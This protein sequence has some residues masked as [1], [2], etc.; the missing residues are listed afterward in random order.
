MNANMNDF[1]KKNFT[2]IKKINKNIDEKL[3]IER[4]KNIKWDL[5]LYPKT[6]EITVNTKCNS[7]CI[8]CYSETEIL[9]N[10]IKPSLDEIY[11]TLYIG[12]KNGSW[13]AVIIGGEPT[14]RKDIGKIANFARKLGYPCIKL[15]TNGFKLADKKLVKKLRDD[16]FNMFDISIH[17]YNEKIHDKLVGIKGAFS[18][19]MKA[20]ENLKELGCEIGTNQVINKIN[21]ST[22]PEFMDFTYNKI[23]INYY[24]IIYEHYIGQAKLNESIL[25]VKISE[26]VPCIIEGLKVIERKS[27]P[28]FARILV[29]IPPCFL[30]QY[31]NILDN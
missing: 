5:S 14:L 21:Y 1:V 12:R 25:K 7:K 31:I 19:I 23:G 9:K 29:N 13:I 18:R 24:N 6:C 26:I 10:D 20:I 3:I 11:K 15:C 28:S 16:G 17:G 8:F 30:P 2:L 27:L 22:F 4:I